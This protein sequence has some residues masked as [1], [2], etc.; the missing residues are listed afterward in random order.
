MKTPIVLIILVVVFIIA[1]IPTMH[2]GTMTTISNV[3][4]T[5]KERITNKDESKYLVFSSN[6]TFENTDSLL[7][8]KFNSS[9]IQGRIKINSTCEFK[10]TGLR[11]P[12][13]SSYRNILKATCVD[14][15]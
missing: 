13:M 7:A 10:V 8:F 2:F 9:D 11:I 12:I 1:L 5:D 3:I 6:E 14:P 15:Q 4:V